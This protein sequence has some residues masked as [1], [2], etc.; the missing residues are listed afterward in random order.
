MY[1]LCFFFFPNVG[2][3]YSNTNMHIISDKRKEIEKL[4]IQNG[5]KYS[6]ELTKKCT[7]LICDI[8]FLLFFWRKMMYGNLHIFILILLFH[9]QMCLAWKLYH[10]YFDGL[11]SA[12]VF[13][14]SICIQVCK[15]SELR[16]IR[17][18]F[19][20]RFFF[21]RSVKI[22][23]LGLRFFLGSLHISLGWMFHCCS[24][25]FVHKIDSSTSASGWI[26]KFKF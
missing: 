14:N 6:P 1:L 24:S 3:T 13:K 8:S 16:K 18:F 11:E 20:F 17:K 9:V 19:L 4:I 21:W 12:F 5:G 2:L 23:L 15:L 10:I 26:Q 25:E 7:H 22:I